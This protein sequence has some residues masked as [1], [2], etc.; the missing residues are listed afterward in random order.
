MT[1]HITDRATLQASVPASAGPLTI[2]LDQTADVDLNMCPDGS[3]L[4]EGVITT[5]ADMMATGTIVS[6]GSDGDVAHADSNGIG[7]KVLCGKNGDPITSGIEGHESTSG[8]ASPIDDLSNTFMKATTILA[9]VHG[10][11]ALTYWSSGSSVRLETRLRSCALVTPTPF[12][13]CR[14]SG[15]SWPHRR[16]E[17]PPTRRRL[18]HGTNAAGQSPRWDYTVAGWRCSRW[19][20]ESSA[21]LD[22]KLVISA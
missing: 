6:S 12:A 7:A 4:A 5:V 13:C 18:V 3:G 15:P 17:S 1:G 11:S 10:Q 22:S 2:T 9:V 21:S 8:T 19:I 14:G 16:H 20:H